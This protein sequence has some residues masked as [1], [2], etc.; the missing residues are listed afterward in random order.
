VQDNAKQHFR[1]QFKTQCTSSKLLGSA[2]FKTHFKTQFTL[3]TG[4]L[5][6]VLLLLP[7]LLLPMPTSMRSLV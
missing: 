6:L 4:P 2:V 3:F 7:L 1:T 5:C